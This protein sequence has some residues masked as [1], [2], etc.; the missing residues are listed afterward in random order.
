VFNLEGTVNLIIAIGLAMTYDASSF[1]G[2]AYWIPAFWV[3]AL[4]VTHALTFV[5][6]WR[7]WDSRSMGLL[8]YE[9]H[10]L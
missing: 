9:S 8:R 5:I 2:P 3:P 6:L 1:M 4:L 7:G 10:A